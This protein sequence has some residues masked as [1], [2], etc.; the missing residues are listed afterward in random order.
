MAVFSSCTS[1]YALNKF[2]NLFGLGLIYCHIV[3]HFKS[4]LMKEFG[5]YGFDISS[6]V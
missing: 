2:V 3:L 6:E 1:L 4:S 5:D